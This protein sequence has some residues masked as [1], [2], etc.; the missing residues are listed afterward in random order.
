MATGCSTNAGWHL[1]ARWHGRAGCGAG[2][3]SDLER[4]GPHHTPLIAKHSPLAASFN[5]PN[6]GFLLGQ[7][8]WRA[9]MEINL[10]TSS[11]RSAITLVLATL[12]K[13]IAGA[14]VLPMMDVIRPRVRTR[15]IRRARLRA[16][17]NLC[18]QWA[19]SSSCGLVNPK[20][21]PPR[22]VRFTGPL[23]TLPRDEGRDDDETST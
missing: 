16:Q 20:V 6:G 19:R 21:P 14:P 4:T 17:G 15:V 2:A 9:L 11:N 13:G 5:I 1:L 18:P 7:A 8:V 23:L 3:G 22:K 10:G 12:K